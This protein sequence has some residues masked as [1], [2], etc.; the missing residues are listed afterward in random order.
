MRAYKGFDKDLKCRGFQYE[1]AK[2]YE[3]DESKTKICRGGFHACEN[4]FD[5]LDHY[6]IGDGNR[7]C[8][9]EQDGKIEK[10]GRKQCSSRIEIKAEI[11]IKGLVSAFISFVKESVKNCKAEQDNKKNA[12]I[13]SSGYSAQIGSSGD[14]ARIGSSGDYAQIGSSGDYEQIG[15]T[16]V[17][18]KIGSSGYSAKI[19]STGYSARIGSS[20]DY[21]QIVSSGDSAQI[22]SSGD[23][24]RIDS[25]G[26]DSVICCAGHNSAARA[27]KGSW[28]TLSEWKYDGKKERYAPA[29]VRA[30]IVDGERIKAGTWYR[31]ENGEFVEVEDVRDDD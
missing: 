26:E 6:G 2:T 25:S 29:C 23:S 28:I 12:Q 22:G 16:G 4:P 18:A 20:G 10:K 1:V 21:E 24:A 14:Y 19:G 31:L 30:E 13:V 9:V 15:S 27:K 8:E 11:G 3:M 7:F 5:V 17:F